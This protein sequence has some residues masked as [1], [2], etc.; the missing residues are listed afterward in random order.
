MIKFFLGILAGF[1]LLILAGYIYVH[2]IGLPVA[3]K[4][5]EM[6]FEHKIASLSINMAL[7]SERQLPS[8]VPAD[9]P[10]MLAGAK[11]Y[12]S[13]CAVCH[14]KL[15]QKAPFIANAMF[16]HAPQLITVE[17]D[18]ITSDKGDP[19]GKIHWKVKYGLR[20]TGMPGFEDALSDTEMWQVTQLLHHA[21]KLPSSVQS[22][23][24]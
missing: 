4:S 15:G 3:V 20:L 23:L 13:S 19:V 18:Y 21:D 7:A 11:V 17:D 10:N 8:P 9:E 14:G 22:A 16:P 24:K 6:P 2:N 5:K 1:C 12:M